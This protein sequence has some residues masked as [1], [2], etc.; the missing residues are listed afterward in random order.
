MYSRFNK[1][2]NQSP[3]MYSSCTQRRSLLGGCVPLPSASPSDTSY[4][5][6][7]QLEGVSSVEYSAMFVSTYV[8]AD[9]KMATI[10]LL[11]GG[12]FAT[13][14]PLGPTSKD[15]LLNCYVLDMDF[16]AVDQ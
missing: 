12:I 4:S 15:Q 10:L 2:S 9:R 3:L 7:L 13:P 16:Q 14:R 1:C 5:E 11:V 6:G 8:L